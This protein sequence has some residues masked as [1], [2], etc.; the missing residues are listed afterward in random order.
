MNINSPKAQVQHPIMSSPVWPPPHDK[1]SKI[2]ITVA[3]LGDGF[4]TQSN[5]II[6][7]TKEQNLSLAAK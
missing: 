5:I 6:L 7:T 3:H 4:H 1:P 2:F